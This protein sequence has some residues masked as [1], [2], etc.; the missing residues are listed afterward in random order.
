LKRELKF[1]VIILAEKPE[2]N[3]KEIQITVKWSIPP[4][5]FEAKVTTDDLR[6]TDD[7]SLLVKSVHGSA[8]SVVV[9]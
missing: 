1:W 8:K 4:L 9:S 5:D 6:F 2:K 7:L 3:N